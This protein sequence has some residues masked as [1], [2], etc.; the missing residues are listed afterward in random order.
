MSVPVG[1]YKVKACGLEF[2]CTQNGNEFVAVAFDVPG[3][4]VETWN[5]YLSEKAAPRTIAALRTMGW[6]GNDLAELKVKDLPGYVI[7]D[8][9]EDKDREGNVSMDDDGKPRTRIAWISSL[10]GLRTPPMTTDARKSLSLRLRK[11]IADAPVVA[12]VLT[13]DEAPEPMREPGDD[14]DEPPAW[15]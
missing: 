4:G 15:L 9:R 14:G 3:Y 1:K 13:T 2:S 6:A 7:A 11:V 5:G 8:F 12:P 10:T